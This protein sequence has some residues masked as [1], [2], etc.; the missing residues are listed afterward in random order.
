MHKN[1]SWSADQFPHYFQKRDI[2][3]FSR[4]RVNLIYTRVTISESS[5][6]LDQDLAQHF[7]GPDLVP[8]L[9]AKVINRQQLQAKG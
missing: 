5:N 2:S 3:R 9:F 1:G 7:V 6:N 8:K 4:T